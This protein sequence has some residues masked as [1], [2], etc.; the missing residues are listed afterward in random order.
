MARYFEMKRAKRM[1]LFQSSIFTELK[2]M[3]LDYMKRTGNTTIDFSVGSPNIAPEPSIM[4]ALQDAI[5]VPENYKYAINELPEMKAAI[6]DWYKDRYHV[7]LTNDEMI[8]LQGSQ[9]ALST[10]FLA[11]C[12]PGDIVLVPDPYYPIFSD[13][14]KIAGA[15][16]EYM[17]L[18]EEYNYIIQLDKIDEEI[19]KK[20]KMMIVSYPNNPTCAIA[21]DSF[22]EELIA[23]AKK[24]DI[25]VLHDNAYSELVFDGKVGKS[26]LSFAGAKE[27]GI[28]L[29]SFSKTYGM[30][31]ARLG[32]CVGNKEVIECYN[33]LKSNMDYGIFLPVQYAGIEALRHGGASIHSTCQAYQDRRDALCEIFDSVG[34]HIASSPATMFAWAKIPD[35]Y[36]DSYAFTKDLLEKTGI[37][38]TPGQAFGVHGKKYVRLALVQDIE[39]IKGAAQR[40]KKSEIFK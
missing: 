11:M 17:P 4:K 26:F 12:D 24:Y 3:K 10:L 7:E 8:C 36:E 14:P 33:T 40:I 20:A 13:G 23:F 16:V 19:A 34:W 5:M 6:H 27:V 38:V 18:L 28:E 25:V 31:G 30:A 1:D 21:P 32:V 9:E 35:P 22:Y 39:D 37:V 29:N 2:N 15:K